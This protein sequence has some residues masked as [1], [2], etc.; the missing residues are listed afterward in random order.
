[1]RL[2]TPSPAPGTDDTGTSTGAVQRPSLDTLRGLDLF[3]GLPD[4]ELHQL[5]QVLELSHVRP[6]TILQTQDVPVRHWHIIVSGHAVVERDATPI[7]LLAPGDSWSEHSIL[8]GMRSSI[9]VVALS[10]TTF[11]SASLSQFFAL[12]EDHPLLAGRLVAR[13]ATSPDR[14]ALP[15]LNALIHLARRGA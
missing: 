2:V 4:A 8:N 10:P 9:G 5:A 11:L 12:P 14:L 15:V 13:S 3:A 6:G 1:M 7:G